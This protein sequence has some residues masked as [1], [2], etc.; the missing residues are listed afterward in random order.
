MKSTLR[1]ICTLTFTLLTVTARLPAQSIEQLREIYDKAITSIDETHQRTLVRIRDE[2][3]KNLDKLVE[4][5]KSQGDL[6]GYKKAQA[7]K[8]RFATE[9]TVPPDSPSD[10]RVYVDGKN[11][12]GGYCL[13]SAPGAIFPSTCPIMIGTSDWTSEQALDGCIDDVMIWNRALTDEEILSVYKGE[14][15]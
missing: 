4:K 8:D 15:P 13:G 11:C 3:A 1:L 5:A 12:T 9:R 7:E 10:M 2:Y 6:N 14:R